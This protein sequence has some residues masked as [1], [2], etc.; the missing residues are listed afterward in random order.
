VALTKVFPD[1]NEYMYF[2]DVLPRVTS[3]PIRLVIIMASVGLLKTTNPLSVNYTLHDS[4]KIHA[5][6]K[7][8]L[9]A[10]KINFISTNATKQR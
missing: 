1:Y 10:A 8:A 4:R 5:L 3:R 6:Q 7:T 2:R 9:F